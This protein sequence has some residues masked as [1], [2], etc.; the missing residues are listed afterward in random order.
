MHKLQDLNA[1]PGAMLRRVIT[2]T[3]QRQV[4]EEL[5]K[6][7]EYKTAK[8]YQTMKTVYTHT[9]DH[10]SS[11]MSIHHHNHVGKTNNHIHQTGA[12]SGIHKRHVPSSSSSSSSNNIS[13]NGKTRRKSLKKKTDT[14]NQRVSTQD[15]FASSVDD[16]KTLEMME[17]DNPLERLNT[18]SLQPVI[19]PFKHPHETTLYGTSL[20]TDIPAGLDDS[21]TKLIR[22]AALRCYTPSFFSLNNPNY[23]NNDTNT[24]SSN[25]N[26]SSYQL[27]LD[28]P[29]G[30][31]KIKYEHEAWKW[32]DEYIN[33][34][35]EHGFHIIRSTFLPIEPKAHT[36]LKQ[37]QCPEKLTEMIIFI[38]HNLEK[39]DHL[40]KGYKHENSQQQMLTMK[41]D[42]KHADHMLHNAITKTP[43]LEHHAELTPFQKW[44]I[45]S[46]KVGGMKST[47][48][49]QALVDAITLVARDIKSHIKNMNTDNTNTT[50][51][52]SLENLNKDV[53]LLTDAMTLPLDDLERTSALFTSLVNKGEWMDPN[54]SIDELI[55]HALF[56]LCPD[57]MPNELESSIKSS[58]NSNNNSSSNNNSDDN[59]KLPPLAITESSTERKED[60]N[61]SN[62]AIVPYNQDQS[63]SSEHIFNIW[64]NEALF[65]HSNFIKHMEYIN[66]IPTKFLLQRRQTAQRRFRIAKT[67]GTDLIHTFNK[68]GIT[69]IRHLL[70]GLYEQEIISLHVPSALYYQIQA[71]IKVANDERTKKRKEDEER[72]ELNDS[73]NKK[74]NTKVLENDDFMNAPAATADVNESNLIKL[75]S[76]N[77]NGIL[78]LQQQSQNTKKP[79]G[80]NSAVLYNVNHNTIMSDIEETKR[81]MTY[82]SRFQRSPFDVKGSRPSS[83]SS[84]PPSRLLPLIT[85]DY[86]GTG[87]GFSRPSTATVTFNNQDSNNTNSNEKE[88]F[89]KQ[90]DEVTEH[91]ASLPQ[92]IWEKTVHPNPHL[93]EKKEIPLLEKKVSSSTTTNGPSKNNSTTSLRQRKSATFTGN[94]N[95]KSINP[96]KAILFLKPDQNWSS[97]ALSQQEWNNELT[98]ILQDN[99]KE[100]QEE[101]KQQ[102]I[103]QQQQQQQQ[104]PKQRLNPFAEPIKHTKQTELMLPSIHKTTPSSTPTKELFAR[105]NTND[106][107]ASTSNNNNPPKEENK[108][109]KLMNSLLSFLNTEISLPSDDKPFTLPDD[110]GSIYLDDPTLSMHHLADMLSIY[111]ENSHHEGG[112]YKIDHNNIEAKPTSTSGTAATATDTNKPSME[113]PT[114]HLDNT[115]SV[116][117]SI[118]LMHLYNKEFMM[119]AK[120]DDMMTLKTKSFNLEKNY[121]INPKRFFCEHPDCDQSFSRMY[122]LSIHMKTHQYCF[123]NYQDYKKTPQTFLDERFT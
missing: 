74:T 5:S 57:Q 51:T 102:K 118:R 21:V 81:L 42:E 100:Q 52:K 73:S 105:Y 120:T 50:N 121:S 17:N 27:Y 24:S 9:T 54:A 92:G 14:S 8:A 53:L 110:E 55:L 87:N 39:F 26:S 75:E 10:H 69:Q 99:L 65:H 98:K 104:Q 76:N 86:T 62:T 123:Q 3:V 4:K 28:L 61:N 95:K 106:A 32:C 103:Q 47:A 71:L 41:Y 88:K 31:A 101:E 40:S 6:N 91:I 25:N 29:F 78:P 30:L 108:T 113:S 64:K 13:N 1:P 96:S 15:W 80:G 2:A 48:G 117:E 56:L 82:D 37:I 63:G 44:L 119:K 111:E 23:D 85:T 114:M 93:N 116:E 77:E 38:L 90:L 22:A 33:T 36:L 34:L 84:R 122:T 94:I 107:H 7:Q 70:D 89:H 115:K 46:G 58:T 12:S 18:A 20:L 60:N 97:Q 35:H 11:D 67:I 45:E 79:F 66:S 43:L 16:Y 109:S 59:M 19:S 49:R 72:G 83:Q 68:I 112:D